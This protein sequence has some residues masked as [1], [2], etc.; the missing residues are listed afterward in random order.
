VSAPE[1]VVDFCDCFILARG[2][3]ANEVGH[4]ILRTD[5]VSRLGA[6]LDGRL[7]LRALYLREGCQSHFEHVREHSLV[8]EKEMIGHNVVGV[9][10]TSCVLQNLLHET[11]TSA[12]PS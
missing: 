9:A 4:S 8:D 11:A 12:H 7:T 6:L 3:R 5:P 10:M 2:Q 1:L